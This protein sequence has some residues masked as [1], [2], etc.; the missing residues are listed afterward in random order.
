[1]AME[2]LQD[3]GLF[4]L[5][6]PA[7][8]TA[9]VDIG[10]NPID[11]APPYQPMLDRRL[12]TVTGFDPQQAALDLLQDRGPLETYLPYA[13]GDGTVQTLNLCSAPGMSSFLKPD[14][15]ALALF[16]LFAEFGKVVAS[17]QVPTRPLDAIAEVVAIDFL[18]MDVQGSELAVLRSGREKLAEA[19]AIQT[20][21]SFVPLYE[22]QPPIGVLDQELRAQ[23]FLPH[24]LVDLKQWIISPLVVNKDPRQALNQLLE[25][26]LVYV[27]DIKTAKSWT[28]EQLKHLALIAH[29]CYRSFDLALFCLL[30][31]ESRSR[32]PQGV[33][34][35]YLQML[36]SGRATPPREID[37]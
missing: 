33:Q 1:M 8:L 3:E 31:L 24:A 12:C 16:P 6:Q 30:E 23:G 11:G 35:H 7:R 22:N 10:A 37:G 19:V 29:H 9:V 13:V 25:A 34:D 20:E 17:Q 28:D 36:R 15:A 21:V 18:K 14:A 26:D 4:Q 32:V 27:R 2:A 5:V